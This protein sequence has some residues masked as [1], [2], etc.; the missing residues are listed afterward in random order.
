VLQRI[1]FV[2][3]L[4][5]AA[6]AVAGAA[7]AEPSSRPAPGAPSFKSLVPIAGAAGGL[8]TPRAR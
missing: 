3:K 5:A 1:V 2:L 7:A 4:A 6:V 8:V